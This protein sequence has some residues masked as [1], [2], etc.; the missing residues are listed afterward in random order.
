MHKNWNTNPMET[1]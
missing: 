1:E